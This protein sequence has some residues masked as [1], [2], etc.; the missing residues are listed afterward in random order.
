MRGGPLTAPAPQVQL[1]RRER[2]DPYNSL[3]GPSLLNRDKFG[4]KKTEWE[5]FKSPGEGSPNLLTDDNPFNDPVKYWPF[6][7]WAFPPSDYVGPDDPRETDD[8]SRVTGGNSLKRNFIFGYTG[9]RV[10]QNLFY[11]AD[12]ASPPAA[13]L[14]P[15]SAST[16]PPTL[17]PPPPTPR[18]PCPAAH[19]PPCAGR[20]VYHSA[21]LGVVY[22]KERHA[23]LFFDG[24]DDD[25]TAL[26]VHPDKVR[27]VTGQIG[28]EPQI[29]VWS[30]RPR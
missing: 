9:R 11:N 22:D 26:D 20:L 15:A 18:R 5:R 30:S 12:G 3:K 21:A 10:R 16:L 6:K 28:R 7:G 19:V 13:P 2:E 25:I 1:S 14:P 17:S 23:Q 24:H 4:A 8:L 29:L 27:V